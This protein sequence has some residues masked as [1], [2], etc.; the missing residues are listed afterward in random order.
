[1]KA[2]YLRRTFVQAIATTA[3]D[4]EKTL[5]QFWKDDG[6][7]RCL[8]NFAWPSGDGTKEC[9]SGTWKKTFERFVLDVKGLV[10][11]E[12]VAKPSKA[13]AEMASSPV[14]GG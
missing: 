10:K 5:M 2:C 9:V 13:V 3:K 6:T 8:K 7:L 14:W 4:T 1:M 11:G 12:E